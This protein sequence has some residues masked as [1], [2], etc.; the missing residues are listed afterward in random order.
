MGEDRSVEIISRRKNLAGGRKRRRLDPRC[1]SP[2]Q[3]LGSQWIEEVLHSEDTFGQCVHVVAG[4]NRDG[5][6]REDR[7]LVV[8][9]VH[10]MH[11]DARYPRSR[12]EHGFVD[13]RPPHPSTSERGQKRRMHIQ[14]ATRESSHHRG[15]NEAQVPGE[16]DH[17]DTCFQ[18]HGQHLVS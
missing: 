17:I 1:K 4:A 11:G 15:G 10:E 3:V 9:L 6:L 14:D 8:A 18:E 16:E 2:A 12:L 13:R 7:T 5:P